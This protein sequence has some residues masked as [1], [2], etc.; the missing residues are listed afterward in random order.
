[1]KNKLKEIFGSNFNLD[2]INFSPAP[3]YLSLLEIDSLDSDKLFKALKTE[4]ELFYS[5]RRKPLDQQTLHKG[6]SAE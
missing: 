2:E 5:E 1:M 3:N 4:L 6:K